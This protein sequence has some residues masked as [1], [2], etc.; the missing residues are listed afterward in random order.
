V[1]KYFLKHRNNT[2]Y[3]IVGYFTKNFEFKAVNFVREKN[4]TCY[5]MYPPEK[6]LISIAFFFA[7]SSV[8]GSSL[9]DKGLGRLQ[10]SGFERVIEFSQDFKRH[11]VAL[12]YTKP[13]VTKYDKQINY[14]DLKNSRLQ[15]NMITLGLIV[16]AGVS[17]VA[18]V[19]SIVLAQ[20]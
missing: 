1:E 4:D 6:E 18:E 19:F 11:N 8:I 9:K 12:N 10:A 17:F 15:E 2:K 7:F 16:S 14:T 5:E 20:I 3:A 13:L